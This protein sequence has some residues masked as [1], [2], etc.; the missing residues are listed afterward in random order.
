MGTRLF[1]PTLLCTTRI[2]AFSNNNRQGARLGD[3]QSTNVGPRFECN[4]RNMPLISYIYTSCG[5]PNFKR[6]PTN[7]N[8]SYIQSVSKKHINQ[9][10]FVR[11]PFYQRLLYTST[12]WA[13]LDKK[14]SDKVYLRFFFKY[15]IHTWFAFWTWTV[16]RC[17]WPIHKIH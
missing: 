5:L 11:I 17:V 16:R 4:T 1:C 10:F 7:K 6:F 15:N 13:R 12:K 3:R 2:S 8:S 9:F 14:R